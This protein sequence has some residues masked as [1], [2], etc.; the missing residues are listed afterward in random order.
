[1][2][3]L[4]GTIFRKETLLVCILFLAAC[5]T[6]STPRLDIASLEQAGVGSYII[7]GVP[8]LPQEEHF[9]GPAALAAV[10]QY[11]EHEVTQAQAAEMAFTP[12]RAGTFQ[13]D[14]ITATRRNGFLALPVHTE[15]R[16]VEYVTADYPV[17]VFQNLGLSWAPR[18]HFSV[19][20]G[21]DLSRGGFYLNSGR[22]KSKFIS[23]K[24][25]QKTWKRA[26]RWAY[27]A[28]PP[29]Q[30]PQ[31]PSLEQLLVETAHLER[32]GRFDSAATSFRSILKRDPNNPRGWFGL[33]NALMATNNYAGAEKAY[34][35][36]IRS[37]PDGVYLYNNLAHALNH[38]GK[39]P[40]ACR[41]LK[42]RL[43]VFLQ[44]Q[45]S[46]REQSYRDQLADTYQTLCTK[47]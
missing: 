22:K 16:I 11:H 20:V 29:D 24:T 4:L 28:V 5:S 34:R 14:M 19:V 43:R 1:M 15:E 23:F 37:M 38:Q 17:I 44:A 42:S 8:F 7:R 46:T 3:C 27:V 25:F 2:T 39:T 33:G 9:C 35:K 30:L 12:G 6:T 26:D 40:E 18:W 21:Y 47:T 36:A 31:L 45:E 41:L 10:L 32:A 13:H